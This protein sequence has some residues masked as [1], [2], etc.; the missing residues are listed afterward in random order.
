MANVDRGLSHSHN[1]FSIVAT[2]KGTIPHKTS[3]R[4]A[5]WCSVDR[6]THVTPAVDSHH[7]DCVADIS[8]RGAVGGAAQPRVGALELRAHI[9]WHRARFVR[10]RWAAGAAYGHA[11]QLYDEFRPS[12]LPVTIPETDRYPS[13]RLPSAS[14]RARPRRGHPDEGRP[15]TRSASVAVT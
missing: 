8:I 11:I 15:F 10:C 2:M 6:D 9:G 4:L 3:F 12:T 5:C 1:H 7:P 14:H 13:P